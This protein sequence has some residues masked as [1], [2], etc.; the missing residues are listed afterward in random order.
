MKLYSI[1]LTLF[2]LANSISFAQVKNP[3]PP[4]YL[5]N[6]SNPLDIYRAEPLLEM[7]LVHT[8]LNLK[9]DYQKEEVLGE[10]WITLKPH[11]Y[12]NNQ[13]I[14]DAKA[15]LIHQVELVKGNSKKKLE[16]KYDDLKLKIDL[17]KMYKRTEQYTLYIK[18]TARP[19]EVKQEGS[20]AISDAKG[21]YFINPRGEEKD[22]PTQIWTQGETVASSCWFP[23]IDEPNQKT[24]QEIYLTVQD[25][26][27][28]LSNGKLEKQTKNTDG[29]RTDYWNF[30]QKHA[31]Y[32]FFVGI[33][34]FAIV[35]DSWKG[36]D[37]RYFVEHEY[38]PY[39]KDIFGDTPAMMTF[40]S[41]LLNYPYPWENY[42]QMVGRD[43]VSGAM[44]NTTA[45]LHMERAQQKPGQLIDGNEWEG[46][47][48]HELFHHWFGDLVTMESFSNVTVNESLA[49][50]SEYLWFEHK[51][52]KEKAEEDRYNDLKGYKNDESNFTKDLVRLRYKHH[53]DLFDG[54][55]YNKGGKGV[56][57]MLRNYLGD[58]AFFGG[59]SKFLHDNQY[60]T[61]EAVQLRLAFESISGR[62]LNWFFDQW[63][64]GS[65][66][67]KLNMAY[68]FNSSTKKMKVTMVQTQPNLFEFPFAIDIVENGKIKRHYV[69]AAKKKENKFEFDV[70]QKPEVV[71]PNADQVLLCDIT[72]NKT[73]EEFVAQYKNG[74]GEYT[75][76]LLALNKL[77][78]AQSSNEMALNTLIQALNDP[79]E[80]IRVQT[81]QL[82]SGQES[83]VK[84]KSMPVLRKLA[85]SDSKTIVQA[86]ALLKLNEMGESDISIFQ[87][88]LKSKSFSVQANAA[89]GILRLDPSQISS[90]SNLA[91]EIIAS[92]PALVGNLIENWIST[93]DTSKLKIAAESVGFYLF[94][95]YENPTLG[96]Q[97]QKGFNWVLSADDLTSTKI[98]TS[99]YKQV[100]KWYA[101]E[102]AGLSMML[103]NL[104]EQAI[105]IKVKANQKNPSKSYEEQIKILNETKESFQ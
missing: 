33:G 103:K 26:Y 80:G 90:L 55:S 65:G 19:N 97:L 28:T 99:N 23:T 62:D 85:N 102:N 77:M 78:D 71:I 53:E 20:A 18:Y 15:M 84:E 101:K 48:A 61:A 57:H 105:S 45:T 68:E 70:S 35:K 69:W 59:L 95:Q 96:N 34:D 31:P 64:F 51:Y 24:S 52:G 44:E 56:L 40:F 11:F 67:P 50:Y 22:K 17:D 63:Y 14:L 46:T 76:R 29:T 37:V 86:S 100:Y 8:K 89:D 82:L 36:K 58:E 9:F 2:L 39:A 6:Q 27:V 5:E 43:Y 91:D 49:N 83:K 66:H 1:G 75:T 98:I 38:A 32:L 73:I 10:A 87:N 7:D 92:N 42:D 79:F 74:K 81:I 47:I 54:V 16:Y 104:I 60:G 4:S 72:D 13:V 93:N 12:E 21:I 88:G 41:D 25:K 94:T 3:L 30:K